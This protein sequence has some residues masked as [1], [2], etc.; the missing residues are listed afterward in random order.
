MIQAS[1]RKAV[2]IAVDTTRVNESK[3]HLNSSSSLPHN[4]LHSDGFHDVARQQLV[5][6]RLAVRGE[7][8]RPATMRDVLVDRGEFVGDGVCRTAGGYRYSPLSWPKG[9]IQV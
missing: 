4:L 6:T 5:F 2:P 9:M 3:N 8:S 7:R 1:T